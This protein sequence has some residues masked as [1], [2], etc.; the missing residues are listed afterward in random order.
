MQDR[1]AV[2][3]PS[4][5]QQCKD[6]RRSGQPHLTGQDVQF[7]YTGAGSYRRW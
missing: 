3:T 6:K 2:S 5:E 1:Q 7:T 4:D